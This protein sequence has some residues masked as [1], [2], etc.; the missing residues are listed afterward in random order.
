MRRFE[1]PYLITRSTMVGIGD[2]DALNVRFHSVRVAH[3]NETENTQNREITSETE[4]RPK[5]YLASEQT[6]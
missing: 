2:R 3:V 4:T 6:N 5:R 1:G